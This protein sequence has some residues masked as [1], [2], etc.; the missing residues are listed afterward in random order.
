MLGVVVRDLVRE[1]DN[2]SLLCSGCAVEGRAKVLS[3]GDE[4]R[5]QGSDLVSIASKTLGS[6]SP[7]P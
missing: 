7:D 4:L 1:W 6:H 3:L 2:L 5:A